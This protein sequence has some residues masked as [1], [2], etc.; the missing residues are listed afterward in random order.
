MSP[1][2]AP[3]SLLLCSL[4]WYIAGSMLQDQPSFVRALIWVAGAV[5]FAF[6][7]LV[8]LFYGITPLF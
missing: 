7:I 1:I 4:L 3:V 6:G 2:V 5:S 8:M